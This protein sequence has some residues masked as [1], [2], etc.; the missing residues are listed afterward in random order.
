MASRWI[1]RRSVVVVVEILLVLALTTPREVLAWGDNG[2]R[3]VAH[4]AARLL[5]ES[6]G[7]Q[8]S[9][10]L[11]EGESLD[12]VAGWAD[13]LRGSFNNPGSR[14]ETARWHF[15][16]I[17]LMSEY[18]AA[19]D[20]PETPNGSC[21][22]AAVGAFQDVLANKRPGYYANSRAE[23]LKFLVHLVGDL[24]Q[25][26]HCV[27]DGDAGGNLKK[28]VWLGGE[29]TKLHAVWDDGI[30]GESM[31]RAKIFEPLKYA[32]RLYS[33]L[34]AQ[35]RQEAKPP[36][37]P[38]PT[39]VGRATLE[40]WT[41][42]THAIARRAYADIGAPDENNRYHLGTAYY[43]AHKAEVDEQLKRAGI[44]LAR[45]LNETLR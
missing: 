6:A 37:S 34:T 35:Q 41:T 36:A 10:L 11:V 30:L 25:P 33:E 44:R 18:D 17:P 2:H 38:T 27:D 39:V 43:T 15:V 23:S 13:G 40:G 16:D 24:H 4:L 28:V 26:L 32:D 22:V 14:P 8:V 31:R 21:V 42:A 5:T 45:I 12:S 19:R 7:H 9:E 29:V 3:I 1:V 20:C